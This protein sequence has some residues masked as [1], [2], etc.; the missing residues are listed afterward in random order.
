MSRKTEPMLG[1]Y[2]RKIDTRIDFKELADV[3]VEAGK[4]KLCRGSSQAGD[5]GKS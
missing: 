2:L 5:S 4:F 1:R 3:I